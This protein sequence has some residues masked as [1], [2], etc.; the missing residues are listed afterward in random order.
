MKITD[1]STLNKLILLYV[2]EAMDV[3]LTG[4]TIIEMCSSA[5]FG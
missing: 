4:R 1:D 2:F 3:P 5:I